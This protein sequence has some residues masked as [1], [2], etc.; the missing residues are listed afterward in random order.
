[1][2]CR[3]ELGPVSAQTYPGEVW[4]EGPGRA[5]FAPDDGRRGAV[6]VLG[7]FEPATGLATTLCSPRRDSASV[8]QLLEQ[9]LQSYPAR[10]WVLITDHLSTHVSRD[11]QT[12]LITWPEVTVWLI[13]TYA[14]WLHLSEPWWKPWRRLALKG[15][16][17][18]DVDEIIA[19]VVQ[20]TED[21]NQH[22]YPYVWKKAG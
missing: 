20:A 13:P 22:R 18:A 6:W 12:A 1:V 19:A 15:R 11:T 14:C 3:D 21:W 2:I 9:G 4:T 8:M 10:A 17:F 7:A 5:P 16:R